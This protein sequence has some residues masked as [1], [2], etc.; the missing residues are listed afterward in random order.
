[1]RDSRQWHLGSARRYARHLG[2]E[3]QAGESGMIVAGNHSPWLK[4]VADPLHRLGAVNKR[5]G[6]EQWA[7]TPSSEFRN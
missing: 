4:T 2:L 3:T 6:A 1:M 7:P 5:F